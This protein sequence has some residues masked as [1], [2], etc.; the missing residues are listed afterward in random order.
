MSMTLEAVMIRL[1]ITDREIDKLQRR[2]V[3]LENLKNEILYPYDPGIDDLPEA[4]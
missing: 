2:K 3:E 4:A 1:S